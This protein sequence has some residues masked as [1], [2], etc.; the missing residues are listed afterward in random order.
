MGAFGVMGCHRLNVKGVKAFLCDMDGTLTDS[1]PFL[2]SLYADVMGRYGIEPSISHFWQVAGPPLPEL[3]SQLDQTYGG[4]PIKEELLSSYMVRLNR[5]YADEVALHEGAYSCLVKAFSLGIKLVLVTSSPRRLAQSVLEKQK[6]APYFE[7]IVAGEDVK[8]GKPD[9]EPYHKAVRL[10]QMEPS[11]MIVIEDS[12][13]GVES[14]L[15]AGLKTVYFKGDQ[16]GVF[17]SDA[18]ALS[19]WPALEQLLLEQSAQEEDL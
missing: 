12:P 6:L 13:L 10:L 4:Q 1:I 8:C 2:Y 7:A 3:L 16:N 19:G 5:H 11:D 17:R 15:S 18:V 14:A 9:P